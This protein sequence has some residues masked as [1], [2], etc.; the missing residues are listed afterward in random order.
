MT[1]LIDGD[2]AFVGDAEITSRLT[3]VGRTCAA[4]GA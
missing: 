3:T 4:G 2:E 1:R